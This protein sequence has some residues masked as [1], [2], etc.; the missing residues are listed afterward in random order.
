MI[1][2]NKLML[3]Y[4]ASAQLKLLVNNLKPYQI[5]ERENSKYVWKNL[6]DV[7]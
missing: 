3:M 7:E 5:S 4:N 1:N 2:L 6:S